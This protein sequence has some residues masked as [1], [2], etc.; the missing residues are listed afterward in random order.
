MGKIV[1]KNRPCTCGSHDAR[2][3][4]EDGTAF[5][6][7]CKK[8]FSANEK[9]E[10]PLEIKSEYNTKLPLEEIR[11]YPIR[12]FEERQIEKAVAE[13]YDV[14]VSYDANGK[15]DTHY[16]PYGELCYKIRKLPKM[17]TCIGKPITL[18]GQDKF[19]S[20]GKRVIITEGEIDAMS[21]AQ[22]Y[23]DKWQ[24]IYP[25][26]GMSSATATKVLLENRDWLRG[27]DEVVLALDEDEA[28]KKATEEAI[29]IIGI[30]KV[31]LTKLPCK[32]PNE[33]LLKFG[34]PK[35][36]QCIYDAAPYV[37]SGIIGKE[38]L[39]DALV[40]YNSIPAVPFP[41]CLEGVNTKLKGKRLGEITLFISGTGSGK[42]T[43]LRE[44]MLYT[45][46]NTPDTDKIGIISLEESPAETARKLAGMV[47][48][49]NPADEEIP[50]DELKI[51]FD[52][53]F[54]K[55]RVILLDHQGSMIDNTV[56]DKL[57]Y[58]CLSGCKFIFNQ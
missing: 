5:C 4:Y 26:V 11:T 10:E 55:D 58:M 57:E 40:N 53:V 49:K 29:K 3:I 42:S 9:V 21:V 30:D 32:D 52:K 46:E 31:K 23:L 28:G 15:I 37:P 44:D 51:G 48:N 39:W 33:V 56:V 18:F 20:G 54:E 8:F 14:R 2:Q 17:F 36:L 16:Y 22:A 12:G 27:F 35:L 41:P 19:N 1:S 6:F 7:S 43:I 38:A 34:G 13:Y 47:L 45:L 24:R 25:V 50:L